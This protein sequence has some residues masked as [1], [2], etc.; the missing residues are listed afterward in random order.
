MAVIVRHTQTKCWTLQS[1]RRPRFAQKLISNLGWGGVRSSVLSWLSNSL[2]E[3]IVHRASLK[4]I[5][6]KRL[7]N[8]LEWYNV[9]SDGIL[10]HAVK[11]FQETVTN[12]LSSNTGGNQHAK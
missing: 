1:K 6:S 4:N 11:I 2:Q 8:I 10:P 5:F 12:S 9:T 7:Q 3:D